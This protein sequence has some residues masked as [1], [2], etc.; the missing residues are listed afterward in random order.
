MLFRSP[1]FTLKCRLATPQSKRWTRLFPRLC[2]GGNHCPGKPGSWRER[3]SCDTEGAGDRGPR[4]CR[5]STSAHMPP[6]DNWRCSR[7]MLHAIAAIFRQ[8]RSSLRPS[9]GCDARGRTV[10]RALLA[11][12]MSPVAFS[13]P[14]RRYNVTV[15]VLRDC[16]RGTV[17]GP[18]ALPYPVFSPRPCRMPL[19]SPR[20]PA[21]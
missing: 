8:S 3:A 18:F 17:G 2:T 13:L 4:L 15:R 20:F 19:K 11:L 21:D 5:I 14:Q 6:S 1:S 12:P 7:A 9:A 10:S 16:N